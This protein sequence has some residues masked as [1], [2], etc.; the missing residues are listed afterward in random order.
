MR[1]QLLLSDHK[2]W[3]EMKLKKY[4]IVGALLTLLA[5]AAEGAPKSIPVQLGSIFTPPAGSELLVQSGRNSIYISNPTTKSSDISLIALDLTGTQAWQRTIDSGVDE[6]ATAATLDPQGNIWLAGSAAIALPLE[7]QT[8]LTGFDNPD[9]VKIDADTKL[10]ADMNNI[11]L[12]KISPTGELLGSYLSPQV[13]L[14]LLTAISATNSGISLIGS[15]AGKPFLLTAT[16]SGAYG[17]LISIGTNKTELNAVA[18]NSDG[19]TSIFGSSSETLAG[20]KVAGIRDGILIKVSKSGAITSLVRSSAQRAS[21]SWVSGDSVNLLSGPVITGKVVESAI[22]KFSSTFAPIWT[23]RLPSAGASTTLTAN[24][25]S[26]LAFTSRSAIT[27]VTGWRP[28]APSL[29]VITFDSKGVMK[30]A[31]ALPGLVT[32]ISFHYSKERG[33]IG[34]ASAADG[35]VSIFTLVSR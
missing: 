5:P 10:R 35:T 18:R 24:G 20:K 27:G 3:R 7:T 6:V 30:A 22:T 14:P 28:T 16:T 15:L 31:T 29:L 4:L 17:K 1:W 33:V 2:N 8:P 23:M 19:S 26:Y 9:S 12:W 13:S 21:R 34:L 11:A 32:P 25:N